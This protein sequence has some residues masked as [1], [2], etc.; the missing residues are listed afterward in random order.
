MVGYLVIGG[1][2]LAGLWVF[3]A[4]KVIRSGRRGRGIVWAR[5]ALEL[6]GRQFRAYLIR[7]GFG[8]KVR[9][10]LPSM[11]MKACSHSA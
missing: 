3:L 1:L 5:N 8:A 4:W 2:A 6:A 10:K 7:V 9:H 11:C